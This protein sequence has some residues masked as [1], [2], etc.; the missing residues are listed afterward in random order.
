MTDLPEF[1]P[2]Q[3]DLAVKKELL[4]LEKYFLHGYKSDLRQGDYSLMGGLGAAILVQTLFYDA[5]GNSCFAEERDKNIDHL[6]DTLSNDELVSATF[7]NGLAGAGWL[8]HYLNK[9]N[10][11]QLDST[12][13]FEDIDSVV[14]DHTREMLAQ[15]NFDPLHG[16]IGTG[17]YFLERKNEVILKEIIFAL[18]DAADNTDRY[19]SWKRPD[20]TDKKVL[21]YD[22]GLAHGNAG[23]IYF[24]TKCFQENILPGMCRSMALSA[25][26]FYMANLQDAAVYG[27]HFPVKLDVSDYKNNTRKQGY[28]RLAW[29]YGDLGVLHTL[30]Y[31]AKA[32]NE[33]T[34]VQKITDLILQTTT[35][36]AEEETSVTDACFCHGASGN[37]YLYQLLARQIK[38]P[39]LKDTAFYWARQSLMYNKGTANDEL[40]YT[41]YVMPG[42]SK[43]SPDLLTGLGG[44]SLAYLSILYPSLGNEWNSIFFLS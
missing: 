20:Y 34:T 7:C 11:L 38:D 28:S 32:L 41:L 8:F 18:Q 37:S 40:D 17:L 1:D 39:A 14:L 44:I 3:L 10:I 33:K 15:K 12:V 19:I 6:L 42:Q 23:I 35:R 21:I 43:Q 29:C 16:S 30:L 4:L 26:N 13:F 31:A 36:K 25:I 22:M 9:R 27:S 2:H 5:T 24:L